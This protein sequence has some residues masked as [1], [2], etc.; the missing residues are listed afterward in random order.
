M[1]CVAHDWDVGA[2]LLFEDAN[3]DTTIAFWRYL[4]V[5]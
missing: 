2:E 5:A 3:A 4:M 1:E